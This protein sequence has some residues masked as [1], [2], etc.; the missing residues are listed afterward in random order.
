MLIQRQ[1]Q[2]LCHGAISHLSQADTEARILRCL[3]EALEKTQLKS[4]HTIANEKQNK[5][6]AS[7]I[8]YMHANISAPLTALD[9]CKKFHVSDRLLRHAFHKRYG[10]GPIAFLNATRSC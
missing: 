9:M 6:V 5:L 7:V 2:M 4:E 3:V 8:E 1:I 10:M